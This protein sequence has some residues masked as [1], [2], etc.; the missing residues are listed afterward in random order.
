MHAYRASE[1]YR[2]AAV[3]VSPLKGVVMLLDGAILFL[4]KSVEASEAKRFEESHNHI[5]RATAILRGLS[6]HLVV[7]NALG[8]R[9]FRTYNGLIMAALASFGRPDSARRYG[10]IIKGLTDLRDAWKHVADT[11]SPRSGSARA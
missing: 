10:K 7:G 6:H 11:Q 4:Q 8:D 2:G 1:A 5:I 9:L 3:T